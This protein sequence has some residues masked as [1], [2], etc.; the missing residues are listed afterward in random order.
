MGQINILSTDGTHK[1]G[2]SFTGTSDISVDAGNIASK[3][4]L[5]SKPTG[6]KN[7]IINGGFDVWQRGVSGFSSG[8]GADRWLLLQGFTSVSKNASNAPAGQRFSGY[9]SR[10]VTGAMVFCQRIEA[11]SCVSLP[12]TN[13]TLSFNSKVVTGALTNIVCGLYYANVEDNFSTSTLISQQIVTPASDSKTTL[14]FEN[15]PVG[16]LNGLEVRFTLNVVGDTAV[17]INQVQLEDGSVATPFEQRPY[18]LELSLCQRYYEANNSTDATDAFWSGVVQSGSVCYKG[19]M[20]ITEKR[21][22]PSSLIFTP[23]DC[24]GFLASNTAVAGINSKGFRIS[25]TANVTTHNAYFRG[26]YTASSEL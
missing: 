25:N 23:A 1:A 7:Y 24:V 21:I 3:T 5:D 14:T 17:T 10:S 13:V 9:F 20:F 18:G 19:V 11:F 26:T 16:V 6:F 2:L 8:Y 15:L 12:S 4:A 22:A